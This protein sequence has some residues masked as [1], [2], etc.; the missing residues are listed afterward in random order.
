MNLGF[1]I[2]AHHQ[3][4]AVRRLVDLL[5]IDGNRVVIH[6]DTSATRADQQAVARIAAE[7]P[8]Q[9]TVISKVHCVWGE[10]SL[11]D[12]VLHALRE[13][14]KLPDR[15]DYIHL[16]SGADFPIRPVAELQEFLRRNPNR[17]FIECCDITQ[18]AWVKGGLGTER[19]R[20]FYPFNFRT[21]R[22]AFDRMVRWQRKLKIRR[23]M[24][25]D[26]KPHMGSQ[27]W[28]LR[29]PTCKKV[30]DFTREH[31]EVPKFF[32][33][34]WIP[35]ESYFQTVIARIIPRWQIAD[36][37]LMFHHL[38][39]AGRPYVFY[40]DHLPLLQRLP[41]FFV[42]KVS[43]E[44]S[45]LLE[46][47]YQQ[48]GPARRIPKV[49]ALVK[50]RELIQAKI[51]ENH[52]FTTGVP[53]YY[54][55]KMQVV[56]KSEEPGG[57]PKQLVVRSSITRPVVMLFV[58][59]ADELAGLERITK[60]HPG[61]CW[62]GR[63]F[64]PKSIRMP[65]EQLA[66]MG[67]TARSWRTRD[68]FSRQFCRYLVDAT[69]ESMIPVMAILPLEARPEIEVFD[70][71]ERLVPVHIMSA[72]SMAHAVSRMKAALF[73]ISPRILARTVQVPSEGV[74]AMFE[75]LLADPSFKPKPR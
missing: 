55:D 14:E 3:P 12:A 42:R 50:T 33:S 74:P 38:T 49:K 7:K 52:T 39:P 13:F 1:I 46:N 47:L 51:D 8:G 10:W 59:N 40:N 4:D 11:V 29:W 61:L 67:L 15:P 63:P 18:K 32:K 23:R 75:A 2:L 28:T 48:N 68:T 69:P 27:W 70:K 30:L 17:D 16:M 19:L 9:V 57:L 21:H 44:A 22:A 64:A 60:S 26:L 72:N 58:E 6:F 34:T 73:E 41:H 5:A 24:P 25:M 56:L 65:A 53:G 20:F 35:D 37:Q 62:L 31:P 66:R 54:Q 45:V 43:P 36:L 71:V